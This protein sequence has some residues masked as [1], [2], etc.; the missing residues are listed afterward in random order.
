MRHTKK[1]F[2]HLWPPGEV[3]FTLILSGLLFAAAIVSRS[4]ISP[5]TPTWHDRLGFA[6]R[7]L[8]AMH[9]SR[10]LTS[11]L[12]TS[13]GIGF[14]LP[15]GAMIALVL[16]AEKLTGTRRVA[17]AF[18]LSHLGATI[19]G[20]LLSWL[21]IQFTTSTLL[22]EIY[23]KRD[24]GPS[25]GYFGCM[26]LIV[27]HFPRPWKYLSGFAILAGLMGGMVVSA[28]HGA[29]IDVSAGLAHLVA[30][31]LGWST[32]NGPFLKNPRV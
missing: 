3:N 13:G 25:A 11:A 12:V 30:F 28:H 9:W 19:G 7:D 23:T 21:A 31:P 15:F 1:V 22:N 18:W 4:V 26:G 10:I 14:W 6:P 24:V 29:F 2:T 5:L 16:A 27:A 8:F 32:A 20:S 17:L